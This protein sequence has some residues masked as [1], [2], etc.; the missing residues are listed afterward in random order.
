MRKDRPRW[1]GGTF[2]MGGW[3]AGPHEGLLAPTGMRMREKAWSSEPP[4]QEQAHPG[5]PRLRVMERA[6]A[7]APHT[8]LPWAHGWAGHRQGPRAVSA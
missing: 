3:W 6:S 4:W 2:R 7:P 1:G 5:T 8:P